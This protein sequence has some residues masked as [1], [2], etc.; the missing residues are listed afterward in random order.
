MQLLAAGSGLGEAEGLQATRRRSRWLREVLVRS[1]EELRNGW[2]RKGA[3]LWK[4]AMGLLGRLSKIGRG[5]W[6][7]IVGSLCGCGGELEGDGDGW[8]GD[9]GFVVCSKRGDLVRQKKGRLS[10]GGGEP[11]PAAG[12]RSRKFKIPKQGFSFFFQRGRAAER[13]N[14]FRFRVFFCCLPT[15]M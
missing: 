1:R 13:S 11:C 9:R 7:S 15:N 2:P 12:R 6:G 4:P 14:R 8:E 3:D 10:A 5:R